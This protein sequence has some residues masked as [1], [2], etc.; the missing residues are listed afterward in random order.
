MN[1]A[2]AKLAKEIF[3]P[4]H[5]SLYFLDSLN[6]Y[7]IQSTSVIPNIDSL[8]AEKSLKAGRLCLK[9]KND[10]CGRRLIYVFLILS[11]KTRSV[12]EEMRLLLK[13]AA[14]GFPVSWYNSAEIKHVRESLGEH[15]YSV[16][17]HVYLNGVRYHELRNETPRS[18][19][20]RFF[21]ESESDFLNEYENQVSAAEYEFLEFYCKMYRV[22]VRLEKVWRVNEMLKGRMNWASIREECVRLGIDENYIKKVFYKAYNEIT[23]TY[24]KSG[25]LE[26]MFN[27]YFIRDYTVIYKAIPEFI[28][29]DIA[30]KIGYIGKYTCFLKNIEKTSRMSNRDTEL[31][32]HNGSGKYINNNKFNKKNIDQNIDQNI[33]FKKNEITK[34]NGD[35]KYE[36]IDNQ[37][38]EN[39]CTIR[40][41]DEDVGAQNIENKYSENFTSVNKNIYNIYN[42]IDGIDLSL[43]SSVNKINIVL[44]WL[45][46]K[47][48]HEFIEKYKIFELLEFINSVFFFKR[49]DFIEKFF[50]LLKKS[51]KFTKN[52]FLLILE[53]SLEESFPGHF[54]NKNIDIFIR[55]EGDAPGLLETF[56]LY[57]NLPYPISV[58]LEEPFVLKLVYIFK[59]LWKLKKID[60]LSRRVGN[61]MYVN[62][63]YSLMFYVFNEVLD[64]FKIGK[65]SEDSLALEMLKTEINSK[66]NWIM[67]N[68][69]INTKEK[70][71]EY[72]LFYMENMFIVAGKTGVF[73]DND[74]QKSLKEFC[75]YAGSKLD[76]TYLF[77]L[78]GFIKDQ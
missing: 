70:K 24:L 8:V 3:Y 46:R 60:Y 5:P 13:R 67:E 42:L 48:K 57:C 20:H 17:Y 52:N 1:K 12:K 73:D 29:C 76:S 15:V 6:K 68:L 64:Q 19:V 69:F 23:R 27:E 37:D 77:N 9:F 16:A 41:G 18:I 38:I 10:D 32:F 74:V 53:D 7:C 22:Y 21:L 58:L 63:T 28:T 71:I 26:D 11:E 2:A 31:I 50:D 30:E 47:L 49:S 51:R 45:N 40:I 33:R 39:K 4:F 78:K 35:K 59:F 61:P 34:K 66:I 44:R 55:E 62:L 72:L 25:R 14:L 56:S 65:M 75:E 43:N 54:F 36:D